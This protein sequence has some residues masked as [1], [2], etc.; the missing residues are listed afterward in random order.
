MLGVEKNHLLENHKLKEKAEVELYLPSKSDS[1]HNFFTVTKLNH[2]I[3]NKFSVEDVWVE[4]CHEE[5]CTNA[6][7]VLH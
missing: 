3:L 2:I 7:R 4:I 1:I 6:I 5:G